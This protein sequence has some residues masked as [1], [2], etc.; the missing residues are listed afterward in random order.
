[1]SKYIPQINETNFV[2]PNFEISE[3]DVDIIHNINN[4]SVTGR[5]TSFSAVT[6]S[7]SSITIRYSCTWERNGILPGGAETYIL[8]NGQISLVSLHM[9]A[10]GQNYYKPW[11]MVDNF[12][13]PTIIS[14]QYVF[15]DRNV[16]ITP[17]MVGLTTF[18]SGTYYF[19]VRFI[20]LKS[21]YPVCQTL[22][23]TVT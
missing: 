12:S 14:P 9:L 7:S 2:Y 20:G 11:R 13:N 21:I 3:Y 19:E 15:I 6:I 8:G 5:V 1:M 10:A 23:I 17:S 22:S 18:V 16:V 4:I